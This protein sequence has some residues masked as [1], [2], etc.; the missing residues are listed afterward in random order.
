MSAFGCDLTQFYGTSETYIIT[1]LRPEQHDPGNPALL[2]SCGARFPSSM[3]G[4]PTPT[5]WTCLRMRSARYWSA[6]R[7]S[8]A[9]T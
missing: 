6:R 5:A 2:A 9:G 8:S 7:W 3:S 4:S 1:L